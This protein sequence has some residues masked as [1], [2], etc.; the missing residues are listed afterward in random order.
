MP[1]RRS[2]AF[3]AG[4]SFIAA[5]TAPAIAGPL[6][7]AP[8]V[9]V[10]GTSAFLDCTADNIAAQSGTVFL[11]SE[12]E[13]WIDVNPTD[14]DNVVG[15]WQQDRWSNGGARGLVTGVSEDGG[16]SWQEVVIPG[17]T[18]CS[19]GSYDRSTDPWV[20][21]GPD[22]TLHQLALSFN[23]I[24]A[25]LEPRDFDHALLA[26]LSTDGGLTWSNPV[27][28][29]RDLDANVFNDKQ[30]ITADPTDA[31]LVYAVWDRL[32]FP[33]SE[34]ANVIA[35]FVTAAFRGPAWF[36]RSTD[37]GLTWEPARQIYDPGQNDQTIG[38]QIVVQPDGTLVDVFNE[39]RNDNRQ[40]RRGNNV[41]LI[42]S[43]D[44]GVSW[45]GRTFV[46]R[47][48][49]IE[50]TDPDTGDPVRTG[51]ILPEAAVDP[52]SGALYVVWQDARFSGGQFDS[53][54]FSQSLDGGTTWSSP[55]K[56]NL[57]PG[58]VP[59]GNQQAFTPSVHVA[60]DGTIAVTYYDFRNNTPS[61]DT[62]PTDYFLVHCHPVAPTS[63]ADAANWGDEVQITDASFDMRLA[64]FALGFFTGD[65]E[66]LSS[67]GDAF[68]PFFSQSH[69][70]DPSST[71]FREVG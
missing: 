13:P 66:G 15:I 70:T 11:N 8:L 38:N 52:A 7:A 51:D 34:R 62:L 33:P 63:C 3:I 49:T 4:L 23:D 44:S 46:D 25:P 5:G 69:G 6:L 50:I 14:P 60:D 19:G 21:F 12:V 71:F 31:D 58:D 45:S 53:V 57:T 29:I 39:I 48:G 9:Q 54:A 43:T 30:T 59:P 65:Y 18:L 64:P 56:V 1:S 26:S 68:T 28:V 2:T 27:E 24:A 55:I 40:G 42:R 10:S 37:G 22:G 20:S 17:I 16:A 47:L 36:A 67:I 35:G 41:A 32:V 61:P